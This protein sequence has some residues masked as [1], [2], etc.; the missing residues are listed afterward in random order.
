MTEDT[1]QRLGATLAERRNADPGDSYTAALVQGGT[2]RILKKVGEE[3]TEVVIA[4]GGDDDSA[5]VHEVADLWYHTLVLL[6]ARGLGP[7]DVLA[8]LERRAGVSGHTEKAAR[9]G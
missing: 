1:L 9:K 7:E 5:L 2:E 3:A 6:A 8:E 4:G